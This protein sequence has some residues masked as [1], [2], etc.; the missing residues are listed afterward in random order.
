MQRRQV[1]KG[2]AMFCRVS[3]ANLQTRWLP[4]LSL[5]E[6]GMTM[7]TIP[8]ALLVDLKLFADAIMKYLGEDKYFLYT[9]RDVQIA[10]MDAANA[11]CSEG[12][13]RVVAR[14]MLSE[15]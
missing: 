14:K 1:Q 2:M 3:R 6:A 11:L 8:Q 13:W 9:R 15:D 5:E 4:Q 10:V 7:N 12:D